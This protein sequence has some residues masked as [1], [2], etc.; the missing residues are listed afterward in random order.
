LGK[1]NTE[2]DSASEASTGNLGETTNPQH[3]VLGVLHFE[4]TSKAYFRK[5]V[6]D[7]EPKL[8]RKA[9]WFERV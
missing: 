8:S 7:E 9:G 6:K 2:E 1:F 5:L 4:A 3:K